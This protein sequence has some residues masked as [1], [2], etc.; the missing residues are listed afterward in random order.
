M[1]IKLI[2]IDMDETLLRTDKTYDQN[3]FEKIFMQLRE[4]GIIFL[5]ASGN[6]YHQLRTNFSDEVRPQLYFAGDNGSFMVKDD[7]VL[8]TIGITENIYRDTIAFIQQHSQASIYVST[9]M[10]SYM[11]AGDPHF[12]TALKYNGILYPVQSFD[13]IPSGQDAYKVAMI[14]DASLADN[15]KL[16]HAIQKQF[17]NILSV[18]S[19][20]IFIDNIH[21]DSGKGQAVSY[22]QNKYNI[23]PSE[24]MVFGDSMNDHSMMLAAKYAIAMSNADPDL[25]ASSSYQIASNNDQAVLTTLEA[26]LA[27]KLEAYLEDKQL[28]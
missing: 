3:R 15:K 17:P 9:G 14:N 13:D 16:T 22:L 20:N 8:Q 6:S 24:T 4:Q 25:V 1:T 23:Q 18:T 28:S 11:L 2:A 27:E 21:K 19:G 7:K 5:I 12:E 10:A 26:L